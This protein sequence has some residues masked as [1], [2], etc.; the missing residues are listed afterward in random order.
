MSRNVSDT[1][2]P[3][4]AVRSPHGPECVI[5]DGPLTDVKVSLL[6]VLQTSSVGV[7]DQVQ[8]PVGH[9]PA[10]SDALLRMLDTMAPLTSNGACGLS[11]GNEL[12]V[13]SRN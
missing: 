1:L 12:S 4:S 3:L 11:V 7:V 9:V 13:T 2:E 6:Q 10:G 8:L 5:L